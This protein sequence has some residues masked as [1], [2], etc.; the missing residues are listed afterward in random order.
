MNE[1]VPK[2]ATLR[3][4]L[5]VHGL[6][7]LLV[8]LAA[9]GV[10][11]QVGFGTTAETFRDPGGAFSLVVPDGWSYQGESSGPGF[12][13][14]YGPGDYDLFYVEVVGPGDAALTPAAQARAALDRYAR[15]ELARFRVVSPPTPGT[16]AGRDASF[17]VYTYVDSAGVQVMEGRGFIIAGADVYTI[18]FADAADRFDEAVAVFNSVMESFQVTGAAAASAGELP[19]GFGV[20]AAM[21]AVSS[22]FWAAAGADGGQS[23]GVY[24]SPGQ[25]YSFVLPAGWE[26]WEEQWTERG[27]AVE[28]WHS[29]LNWPGK[30]V[31]KTLFIW[32]FFDEWLQTGAQYEIVAA[33]VDNV[34]GTQADAVDQLV[35]AVAGPTAGTYEGAPRRVRLGAEAAF[36]VEI[37]V[38]PG[39]TELWSE[40]IPWHRDVTFYVLKRGTALFVLAVPDAVVDS[41]ELA[42]ALESFTWHRR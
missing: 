33:V 37:G 40:G 3:R 18:A 41:P 8:L 26:L 21:A 15:G 1:Q 29:L 17:V 4:A 25:F 32:D 6:T 19:V 7:L 24:T 22:H 27:D 5:S 12:A 20:G 16:L 28:P 34:P 39:R 42:G 35:N 23:A 10:W 13:L 9:A 31:A 14:F 36:A 2:T 38:R 30:P 11:A